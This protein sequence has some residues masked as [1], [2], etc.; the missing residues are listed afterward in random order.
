MSG[1]VSVIGMI[2]RTDREDQPGYDE[3]L[4]TRLTLEYCGRS[5]GLVLL[6]VLFCR[7]RASFRHVIPLSAAQG[8]PA[9][10]PAGG[11]PGFING[12]A[13]FPDAVAIRLLFAQVP[14]RGIGKEITVRLLQPPLA[15]VMELVGFV[16]PYEHERE[17]A[18]ALAAMAAGVTCRRDLMRFHERNL[19]DFIWR[20][21]DGSAEVFAEFP[22]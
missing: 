12:T 2:K 10:I 17:P 14:A 13:P 1:R 8:F 9:E 4:A 11:R 6:S 7:H 19:L 18:A 15:E 22:L 16:L 3:T 5:S 20:K 21:D